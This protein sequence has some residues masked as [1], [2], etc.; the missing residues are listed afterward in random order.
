MQNPHCCDCTECT[1]SWWVLYQKSGL[2]AR[3][4]Q[5][6]C[7]ETGM[8]SGMSFSCWNEEDSS[9]TRFFVLW[10]QVKQVIGKYR[11]QE[12]KE[13]C[14][15]SKTS[16]TVRSSLDCFCALSVSDG[17]SQSISVHQDC[18]SDLCPSVPCKMYACVRS[19]PKWT[20]IFCF[21]FAI[22]SGVAPGIRIKPGLL[23]DHQSHIRVC[24]HSHPVT[25][26]PDDAGWLHQTCEKEVQQ[27]RM[28][29]DPQKFLKDLKSTVSYYHELQKEIK[30]L[31]TPSQYVPCQNQFSYVFSNS[32]I[33]ALVTFANLRDH[34]SKRTGKT[35]YGN[36]EGVSEAV[37]RFTF[38]ALR[39][40]VWT[41]EYRDMFLKGE[42]ILVKRRLN[43]QVL[44]VTLK[45]STSRLGQLSK[46]W[47]IPCIS[48][49]QSHLGP[50]V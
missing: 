35:K 15:E 29:I 11:K 9:V 40:C 26:R 34:P 5:T 28:T 3:L 4:P 31:D 8:K 17:M 6:I 46:A 12:I 48:L 50:Y 21:D 24:N 1:L 42:R 16:S 25:L 13:R 33:D 20:R 10:M 44:L 32:E 47:S 41:K 14:S 22:L 19:C 37:V 45:Y 43:P 38:V 39:S 27:A 7:M 36:S 18:L 2:G 30:V 49:Q 23:Y